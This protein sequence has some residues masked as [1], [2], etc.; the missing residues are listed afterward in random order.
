MNQHDL[1]L[2]GRCLIAAMFVVSALGKATDRRKT[3]N[4]TQLHQLPL[5]GAALFVSVMA[6]FTGA[7]CLIIARFLYPT[8]ADANNY[9]IDHPLVRVQPFVGV[10][11][12]LD[13][14]CDHAEAPGPA[15]MGFRAFA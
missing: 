15:V 4:V 10:V 8:V 14:R 3:I 5:P 11:V 12:E 9:R 13:R 2:I 7:I 6:E 1:F